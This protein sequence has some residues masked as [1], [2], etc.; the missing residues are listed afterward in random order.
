MEQK[1]NCKVFEEKIRNNLKQ[2]SQ[3]QETIEDLRKQ[4]EEAHTL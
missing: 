3:F 4:Q 1:T 2:I